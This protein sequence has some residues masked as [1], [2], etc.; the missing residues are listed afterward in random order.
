[1]QYG[2]TWKEGKKKYSDLLLSDL[3]ATFFKTI[4]TFGKRFVSSDLNPEPKGAWKGGGVEAGGSKTRFFPISQDKLEASSEKMTK[5]FVTY[6]QGSIQGVTVVGK[7]GGGQ[8]GVSF[9]AFLNFN[10]FI[11]SVQ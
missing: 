8:R 6:P 11:A 7:R 3:I 10:V 5:V 9:R 1:M 2:R 4:H